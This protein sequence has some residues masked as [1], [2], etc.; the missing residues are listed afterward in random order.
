[1]NADPR[2]IDTVDDTDTGLPP[3]KAGRDRTV[4]VA[5]L[6]GAL[7]ASSCCILPLVLFGVGIS[8]VWTG[9]LTALSP[10]QPL[11]IAL[12]LPILGYGYYRVYGKPARVCADGEICVRPLPNA[13]LKT[14]LW[15]ATILITAAV[16]FP[17]VAPSLLGIA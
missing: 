1:M 7:A 10:Y 17:Y 15:A 6:F 9:N 5:G 3:Q 13:L 16:A 4:I 11:F 14:G 2:M 8:G 12:T